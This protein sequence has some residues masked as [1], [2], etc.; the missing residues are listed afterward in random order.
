MLQRR[1]CCIKM[2]ALLT[3]LGTIESKFHF[4][5]FRVILATLVLQISFPSPV[6]AQ[7]SHSG[8]FPRSGLGALHSLSMMGK[9]S[10]RGIAAAMTVD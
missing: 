9:K 3:V 5:Y 6:F 7:S 4:L 1:D 2:M 10:K 8:H